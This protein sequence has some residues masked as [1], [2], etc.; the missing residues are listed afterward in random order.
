MFK[1]TN[2]ATQCFLRYFS[3][4]SQRRCLQSINTWMS[5]KRDLCF[6]HRPHQKSIVFKSG[7]AGCHISLLQISWKMMFAP[8]LSFYCSVG[9][10]SNLLEGEKIIF[11]MFFHLFKSWNQNISYVEVCGDLNSVPRKLKGTSRFGDCSPDHEWKQLMSVVDCSHWLINDC[12]KFCVHFSFWLL[13]E[14]SIMKSFSLKMISRS[15]VPAFKCLRRIF[16]LCQV[17]FAF[18]QVWRIFSF[19]S[20]REAAWDHFWWFFSLRSHWYSC[21]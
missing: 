8:V 11:E 20:C 1:I 2:R 19:P 5:Y 10:C 21:L 13:T 4:F 18:G 16:V 7:D 12:W 6:Q 9:W 14:A 17:F 3:P 15:A